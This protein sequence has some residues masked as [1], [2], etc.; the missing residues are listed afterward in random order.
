MKK[1]SVLCLSLLALLLVVCVSSWLVI[2]GYRH[3]E[4]NHE[5]IQ[6]IKANDTS[7]ALKALKA[8]AD[9]NIRDQQDETPS[10]RAY[11]SKLW[12]QMRGIKPATS[13]V[14]PSALGLAVQ[15]DNLVVVE[16]LLARGAKTAREKVEE[17]VEIPDGGTHLSSSSVDTSLSL[18]EAAARHGN[19][20]IVKVLAKHGCNVNEVN[21]DHATALF[22]AADAATVE[23]LL[24]CGANINVKDHDGST[25]L[26]THLRARSTEVVDAL[27][28]HGAYNAD[29]MPLAVLL[30]DSEA[31]D[32]MIALGWKVDTPDK[33]GATPLDVALTSG[34]RL[35]L[36]AAS[37]LIEH[38]ANVNHQGA[39]GM[40]P[41]M[42]AA[43]GGRYPPMED[44]SP[45]VMEA[46]LKR[47][48]RINA[49]DNEG[50]TA[51][52]ISALH[53]R[54]VLV[55]LLLRHGARA[56]L[57]TRTGETALSMAHLPDWST[58]DDDRERSEVIRLLKKAGA[59]E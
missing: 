25:A 57:K 28:E 13:E 24:A 45:E 14:R 29:A 4:A 27:L 32:Q 50:R 23:V 6:A 54:P 8:Q 59:K 48:S 38:G 53:L 33:Y 35:N 42:R 2:R 12:Q 49:Q 56:N 40:T 43:D 5:L 18:I 39:E 7:G 31:L 34:G 51:L 37:I 3:E 21:S 1:R 55:R 9:P 22:F 52:M 44:Q 58:M 46:L 26:D 10:L 15:K 17:D 16:A 19:A 41:L 47:G 36:E 11:L 20:A 30:N